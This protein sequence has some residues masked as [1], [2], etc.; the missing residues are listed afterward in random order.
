MISDWVASKRYP[1]Y[2]VTSDGRV[3]NRNHKRLMKEQGSIVIEFQLTRNGIRHMVPLK[4][5]MTERAET[6]RA[7]LGRLEAIAS[8]I[9]EE[10][11][12]IWDDI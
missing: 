1:D 5:L 8:T 6:N 7:E 12:E 10:T 2:E 11:G 3:R 4:H 9:Q